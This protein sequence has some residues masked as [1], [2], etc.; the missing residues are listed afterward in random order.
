M[1]VLHITILDK[2]TP[3]FITFVNEN[4]NPNDH[5]CE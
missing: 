5:L 2:F 4:F 3:P 1:K